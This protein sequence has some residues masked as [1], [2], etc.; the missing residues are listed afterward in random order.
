MGSGVYFISK[1]DCG[2]IFTKKR[3]LFVLFAL[4]LIS[5]SLTRLRFIDKI[6]GDGLISASVALLIFGLI[7]NDIIKDNILIMFFTKISYS[8]YAVHLPLIIFIISIFPY[9]QRKLQPTFGN[10]L[11]CILVLSITILTS[12]V[13]YLIF[14]KNTNNIKRGFIKFFK[15]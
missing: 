13:F 9:F 3:F 4:V 6:Q 15:K 10:S 2:Q 11:L 14:E 7:K 5:A 1:K 8:L 12:W